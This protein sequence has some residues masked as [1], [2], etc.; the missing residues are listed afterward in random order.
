MSSYNKVVKG[1]LSFKGSKN[2]VSLKTKQ[3]AGSNGNNRSISISSS[4]ISSS[5]GSSAS[6]SSNCTQLLNKEDEPLQ[7]ITGTGRMTTSGVT[8]HGHGTLFIEEL[9]VGDA[10]MII[11]P[12]TLTE[13]TKIVRMVLSN[14]SIGI[15]SAFSTDLISQTAFKYIKVPKEEDE[16]VLAKAE[17]EEGVQRKRKADEV[18]EHAFGKL[19]VCLNVNVCMCVVS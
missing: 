13:E 18:E 19:S 12:T 9:G 7:I 2:N 10:I 4:T 16:E 15:S 17:R 5:T 3:P 6:T 1:K 11:H 14:I 8:V